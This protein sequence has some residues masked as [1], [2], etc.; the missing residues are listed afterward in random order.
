MIKNDL[1]QCNATPEQASPITS[2]PNPITH[3]N[4]VPRLGLIDHFDQPLEHIG[5]CRAATRRTRAELLTTHGVRDV[6]EAVDR[7]DSWAL[8]EEIHQDKGGLSAVLLLARLCSV[9]QV[10][11]PAGRGVGGGNIT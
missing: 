3:A 1:V 9:T 5:V 4:G 6:V 2:N 11:C 10:P 8:V 7:L